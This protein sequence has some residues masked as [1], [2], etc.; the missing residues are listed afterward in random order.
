MECFLK[1]R[2]DSAA[3]HAFGLF[4][5]G[6]YA[7]YSS[8]QIA[9]QWRRADGMRH[10]HQKGRYKGWCLALL[11]SQGCPAALA[12]KK[13]AECSLPVGTTVSSEYEAFRRVAPRLVLSAQQ[14]S[15]VGSLLAQLKRQRIVIQP[16]LYKL[17][18]LAGSDRLIP[19]CHKMRLF[20]SQVDYAYSARD[21]SCLSNMLTSRVHICDF[22]A[23][24]E[25][26]IAK[27]AASSR[28]SLV[29]GM[30]NGHGVPS[31]D[32]VSHLFSWPCWWKSGEFRQSLFSSFAGML[33][34]RGLPCERDVTE[35]LAWPCWQVNGKFSL[36]FFS[37]CA[38]IFAGHGL[39]KKA[40][41]MEMLSWPC[42]QVNGA[43]SHEL[44][45]SFTSVFSGNGLPKKA[46][47]EML[48]W[49]C[50]QL[51]GAFSHELFGS[52]VVIFSG[53]RLPK[54]ADVQAIVSWPCWRVNG[55]F[56]QQRFR[57]FSSLLAGLG[58]A[59]EQDVEGDVNALLSWSCWQR[60]GEFNHELLRSFS[61]MLRGRG[62]PKERAV[63][64]ILSWPVWQ[65]NGEFNYE[66]FRSFA[67]MFTGKGLPK[68][69]EVRAVL[70]WPC[71][72]VNDQFS[73]ELFRPIA[74][75]FSGKGLPTEGA[76]REI[77]S[78]PAW[79]VNGEF[80]YGLFRAFSSQFVG[81]GLPREQEV[82]SVLSWPVWQMSGEFNHELFGLLS[83]MCSG[84]ELLK[85][86][87]V[88]VI[89]SWPCWRQLNGQFNHELFHSF[90]VMFSGKGLPKES[91]VNEIL[92]WPCW[93]VNGQ[94]SHE[95]F[96][97]FSCMF[98]GRG[99][100]KEQEVNAIL[101]WPYWQRHGEINHALLHTFSA[102]F[103]GKGLPEES[104]VN[105][106]LSWPI[107]TVSGGFKF[108]LFDSI[109][110]IFHGKGLPKESYVLACMAWLLDENGVNK[111]TLQLMRRLYSETPELPSVDCLLDCER[112][113]ARLS[114]G[115]LAD[116]I[117]GTLEV[118]QAAL[119]L[120]NRGGAYYLSQSECERFFKVYSGQLH[121]N[122]AG[123]APP[124]TVPALSCL[125]RVLLAHGGQ[126]IRTF[127][128][129]NDRQDWTSSA[130]ERAQQLAL[131]S[132]PVPLELIA[133]AF[134]RVPPESWRDYIYFGRKRVT[135][136]DCEQWHEICD[137]RRVLPECISH[138][139]GQRDF[140]DIAVTLPDSSK[141]RLMSKEAIEAVIT[142]FPS[143]QIVRTLAN[144]YSPN[145]LAE[146]FCAA[147]D[148]VQGKRYD[149]AT[150]TTLLPVLLQ[151]GLT[152]PSSAPKA[153]LNHTFVN[154][155]SCDGGGVILHCP[156]DVTD[157]E[158]L[159]HLFVATFT[160]IT[161]DMSVPFEADHFTVEQ[162]GGERFRFT[163]PK[164]IAGP[165]S[166]TIKNWSLE[167]SNLFFDV[168]E[169]SESCLVRPAW[170]DG[171]EGSVSHRQQ[172]M[173][174]AAAPPVGFMPLSLG[175]LSLLVKSKVPFHPWVWLSCARH[176]HKLPEPLCRQ[177]LPL[178]L[179][180][181]P[182]DVPA[183]FPNWLRGR[184]PSLQPVG[185]HPLVPVASEDNLRQLWAVLAKKPLLDGADLALLRNG[186]KQLSLEQLTSVIERA[187]F[188]LPADTLE[189]WRA[190]LTEAHQQKVR[191]NPLL[192]DLDDDLY[193][194]IAQAAEP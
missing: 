130:G 124:L 178:A 150:L 97:L 66:L 182:H 137:W 2:S 163:V 174:V 140:I 56:S 48:S 1:N 109:L 143:V 13:S 86:R 29:A 9:R 27:L 65:V 192:L 111:E 28:L 142:L 116:G 117:Q 24:E 39:P 168:I 87:D 26:S 44:F 105:A 171:Q 52:F 99:L 21:S 189:F 98:K 94:F 16:S 106:L 90:S 169:K 129:V 11:L 162:Y 132:L 104:D 54:A 45:G 186:H 84:K 156:V 76:V 145:D 80:N 7:S 91:D 88:N 180:A 92:S 181:A 110:S 31:G 108:E 57:S 148:Y 3:C 122:D 85:E 83:S 14:Q 71:W 194:L 173:E 177:L 136:P 22:I 101:S 160:T 73:Y 179:A 17:L 165:H 144:H 113:L 183:E 47:M 93:S 176:R 159:L 107:W 89:L 190:R 46:V 35:M 74:S 141:K 157:G 70:A 134:D 20:F 95:L 167:D 128:A 153:L 161:R 185:A 158:E 43:F 69:Q 170:Q 4:V 34:G 6:V 67:S 164:C 64:G 18:V 62:L 36:A 19:F 72:R 37:S 115:V 149:A 41:V 114:G 81:R 118:K 131:L 187:S 112:R 30:C 120:A 172:D 38:S 119:F 58:L 152:L 40:D 154:R 10:P 138:S 121:A 5:Q 126:G 146:L 191:R 127:F 50:W 23:Q 96:R 166:L 49:P 53:Q 12:A 77:L 55:E 59:Q 8:S 193:E 135:P 103:S 15:A 61:L 155:E 79:Q 151:N 175:T 139:R 78:W 25:D 32:S 102:M 75:M 133:G 42:W 60:N 123:R 188:A 125:H 68:E 63:Q 82:R 33:K 100:P 51:N 184:C 147:L